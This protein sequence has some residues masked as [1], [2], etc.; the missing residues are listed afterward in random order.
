MIAAGASP[1]CCRWFTPTAL[2]P[3][4]WSLPPGTLDV[5][6]RLVAYATTV[7]VALFLYSVGIYYEVLS[8]RF[9]KV[10]IVA[11]AL[12]LSISLLWLLPRSQLRL[13]ICFFVLALGIG[14]P[15][16]LWSTHNSAVK[17]ES[18][19]AWQFGWDS[20]QET[21]ETAFGSDPVGTQRLDTAPPL[22]AWM[23]RLPY[24]AWF[25]FKNTGLV[26]PLLVAALLWKRE[27][28]LVKRKLLFFYL[29]FTLCFIIPNLVRLAPWVWDNVK[30]I[31]YWWLASAPI[32]ALLL[33]RL[34][35]GKAS[36]RV[37]AVTC[38]V[39]LTLA[40]SLDVFA[41]ITSRTSMASSTATASPLP[42]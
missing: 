34:W 40:G 19:I 6:A 24:V 5:L 10:G 42:G 41:L 3:S 14:G 12:S 39:V 37:L 35:E 29:P 8:A 36:Q 18:F 28:Y 11:L 9:A 21:K 22:R 7:L 25:W 26:I 32:I 33:A 20:N 31:F 16:I 23:K 1:A 4:C 15:Q 38:L 30:V 2:L 27:D 17:M 13:W